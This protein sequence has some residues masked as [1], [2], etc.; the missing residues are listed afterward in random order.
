MKIERLTE[1]QCAYLAGLLDGE[2]TIRMTRSFHKSGDRKLRYRV[3]V[4]V[5]A[6]TS[7]DLVSWLIST[8]DVQVCQANRRVPNPGHKMCWMVRMSEV[9][10]ERLLTRLLPYLVIKRRQAELYLRYRKVQQACGPELRWS[11]EKMLALRA[12]RDWFFDQFRMLNARGT[13][14]VTA[15]TPETISEAE[16]VKIESDLHGNMQRVSGDTAPPTVIQ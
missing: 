9:P 3:L 10:G 11:K 14:S 8:L 13:E 4:A 12:L 7:E 16:V 5:A 2:G 6:T 15:N 1:T